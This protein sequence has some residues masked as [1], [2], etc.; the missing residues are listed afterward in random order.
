MKYKD[1]YATLGVTKD[2]TQDEIKKAYRKLARAYHPDLNKEPGAEEKFKDIGE[3]H[4]VLSDPEKRVAYDQIGSGYRQG[5][6]FRPPPNWDA[7]F[8]FSD[9]S[10][11][12]GNHDAVFSDFFETLFGG[13]LRGERTRRDGF[14]AKGR[15]HHAK[16]LID[17]DDA[18]TGSKRT[19]QLK[20]P[21]VTAEGR[22]TAEPHTISFEVPKGIRAGQHI[23]LKGKGAPGIGEGGPGD[24]YLEVEFAP[25]PLYRTE[26]RDLYLNLPLAPWEAALGGKVK[27]P[28]PKGTVDVAVPANS[29]QGRKLR[30]K[31]RGIPGNPPGDL[32]VVL[33]ISL[34]SADDEVAR[35]LYQRMADELDFDPRASLNL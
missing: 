8:E 20:V 9:G 19:L 4:E 31:G 30:L 2:A 16:V 13:G 14:H 7:G 33:Q 5:Q 25:H 17:L 10:F 32:Y 3:A 15:D 21:K 18:F 27:A 34:P 29:A 35:K 28:T 24:L 26:G 1:Y 12:A 11:R 6:D 23:R 22:V